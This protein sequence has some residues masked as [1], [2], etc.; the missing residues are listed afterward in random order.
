MAWAALAAVLDAAGVEAAG[1]YPEDPLW[2]MRKMIPSW[3]SAARMR[4]KIAKG[5]LVTQSRASLAQHPSG[6][7][8]L[9]PSAINSDMLRLLNPIHVQIN[10]YSDRLQG[11]GVLVPSTQAKLNCCNLIESN[12]AE[13]LQRIFETYDIKVTESNINNLD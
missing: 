1:V 6:L 5:L 13:D 8:R 11:E 12:I 2:T 10:K 4:R 9:S 7:G 3:M